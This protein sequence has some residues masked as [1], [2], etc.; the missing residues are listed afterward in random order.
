M[1]HSQNW[2]VSKDEE[3]GKK[4]RRNTELLFSFKFPPSLWFPRYWLRGVAY[5]FS[6]KNLVPQPCLR[7]KTHDRGAG[8]G[9]RRYST[10]KRGCEL[11][12]RMYLD[13]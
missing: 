7:G 10:T 4:I 13:P 3:K 1:S 9:G 12:S 6:S 8:W 11:L 5:L 2:S